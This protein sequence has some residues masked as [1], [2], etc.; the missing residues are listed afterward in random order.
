M[1]KKG[2]WTRANTYWMCPQWLLSPVF[3]H[4]CDCGW[5]KQS[6]QQKDILWS[7]WKAGLLVWVLSWPTEN[8]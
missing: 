8:L 6:Y 1:F 2:Q 5:G 7:F 3:A 4:V